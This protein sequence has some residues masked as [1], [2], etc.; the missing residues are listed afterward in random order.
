MKCSVSEGMTGGETIS[1]SLTTGR[2]DTCEP[3]RRRKE[4]KEQMS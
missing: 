3:T 4:R 2:V 1:E